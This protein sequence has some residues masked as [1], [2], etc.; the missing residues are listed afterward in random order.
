MGPLRRTHLRVCPRTLPTV[1]SLSTYAYPGPSLLR[2]RTEGRGA[3]GA[4]GHPGM[5][6]SEPDEATGARE[7]DRG[8]QRRR[9]PEAGPRERRDWGRRG[10][11]RR[12]RHKVWAGP[13]GRPEEAS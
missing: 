6:R 3:Y 13:E 5:T 2:K 9:G 7:R 10:P 1:V 12:R 4:W 8:D 11:G